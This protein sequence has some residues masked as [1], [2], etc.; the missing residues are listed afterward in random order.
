MLESYE[1]PLFP[2]HTV[3]F[4]GQMLPLRVFEPR[5]QQMLDDCLQGERTFGVTLIQSGSEVG[6]AAIPH[7]V[8]TSAIIQ[9]V[10]RLPDGRRQ[11]I[12]RGSER[13][14]LQEYWATE[15]PYLMCRVHNWPWRASRHPDD[16]LVQTVGRRL[17]QYVSLWS[18]AND[19]KVSLEQLPQEPTR[20][21]MLS[22]IA[23]QVSLR[24]KQALLE[25]PSVDKLLQ[26][27]D[28]LLDDENR[29]LQILLAAAPLRGEME[30]AFSQ[31]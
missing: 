10:V 14:Q 31:N 16:E 5:Y 9:N 17:E 13:F 1:L 6:P 25:I 8:G 18:R 3:L 30:G 29:A 23:L 24:Q 7:V 27:L 19:V 21:A 15:K 22:A 28:D 4:P 12:T 20:L 2:L 11:I 26:K